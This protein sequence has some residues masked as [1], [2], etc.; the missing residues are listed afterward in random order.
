[1]SWDRK[2]CRHCS[3]EKKIEGG[4]DTVGSNGYKIW[5]CAGCVQRKIDAKKKHRELMRKMKGIV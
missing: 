4:K 5:I 1:M 3:S 2:Y